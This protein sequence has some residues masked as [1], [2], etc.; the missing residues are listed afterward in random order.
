MP[1][2]EPIPMEQL[3][4]GSH[5]IIDGGMADGLYATPLPLHPTGDTV[6]AG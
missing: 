1:I 6:G 3:P 5:Q 2:I 4:P